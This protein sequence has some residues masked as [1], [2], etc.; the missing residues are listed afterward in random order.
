[1]I[2]E[3]RTTQ[4]MASLPKIY[5]AI[6]AAKKEVGA[7]GKHGKV[8]EYGKY[9]Y[10][11]F[12]DVLDAVV[13]ILN[14]FGIMVVATVL[15]REERQD[16]KKHFVT[17]TMGYKLYAEDGSFI[18]GSSVGE[19]F[20]V[21]DKA[22]TKAQT[23][24]L[25]IF[26]CT[27]FNIPYNDM[28]DPESGDQHTWEKP[29]QSTLSRLIGKLISL[30]EGSTLNGLVTTAI[31]CL[32]G[33]QERGDRLTVDEMRKAREE[34]AA[35]ARRLRFAESSV[36]QLT[37]RID[38]ALHGGST[39]TESAKPLTAVEPVR[40]KE[41]EY[42]FSIAEG[43]AKFER[44]IL[45]MLQS[46]RTG[47]I[48]PAELDQLVNRYCPED[49]SNGGACFLMGLVHTS[50]TPQELAGVVQSIHQAIQQ[51]EVGKDVGNALSQYAQHQVE[52][53][54]DADGDA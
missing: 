29:S 40:F 13:P 22:A 38:A 34:F 27:T 50:G 4:P 14:D 46:Y 2:A 45:T 53:I 24:A 32:N 23:V 52:R 41:L 8:T 44:C 3:A 39:V 33:T 35:T 36:K 43:D 7:V 25:R 37:D 54:G 9:D 26:Y 31:K 12:D 28:K 48:E 42:D 19:A 20:D 1:M 18:D 6:I 11:R 47:S 10:R 21:G 17:M 51:K 30:Q 15:G 49:G 5:G 16:G